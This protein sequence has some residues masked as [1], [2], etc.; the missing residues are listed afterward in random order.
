[1]GAAPALMRSPAAL[2]IAAALALALGAT[3]L[4]VRSPLLART[5][6]LDA[7]FG[8]PA[9]RSQSEISL[10]NAAGSERATLGARSVAGDPGTTVVDKGAVTA[11]ILRAPSGAG[12]DANASTPQ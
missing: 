12:R 3:P 6:A 8:G 5:Q 4:A 2:A 10:L 11:T 9:P 1:M 7:L